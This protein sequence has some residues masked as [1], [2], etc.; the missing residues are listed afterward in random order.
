MTDDPIGEEIQEIVDQLEASLNAPSPAA[1]HA[2]LGQRQAARK[3]MLGAVGA[4]V[5]VLAIG[6]GALALTRDDPTSTVTADDVTEDVGDAATS[7]SSNGRTAV[8]QDSAPREVDR[9][10][11]DLPGADFRS[12]LASQAWNVG[13]VTGDSQGLESQFGRI[14][15]KG[16]PRTNIGTL[17]YANGCEGSA[18]EIDWINDSLAMVRS[19]LAVLPT[20]PTIGCVDVTRQSILVANSWITVNIASNT[21]LTFGTTCHPLGVC[22]PE[23]MW[24]VDLIGKDAFQ[25]LGEP[26]SGQATVV[27]QECANGSW[28]TFDGGKWIPWD[29]PASWA[30]Q[31]SVD[32]TVTVNGTSLVATDEV[33][34]S[35]SFRLDEGQVRVLICNGFTLEQRAPTD[36]HIFPP[37][38]P[39]P[40]TTTNAPPTGPPSF[41]PSADIAMSGQWEVVGLWDGEVPIDLEGFNGSIG[42]FGRSL[43]GSDGCNSH[44][45]GLFYATSDGQVQLQGGTST[46]VGC[47]DNEA[48]DLFRSATVGATNWGRTATGALVLTDGVVVVEFELT[49]AMPAATLQGVSAPLNTIWNSDIVGDYDNYDTNSSPV[50]FHFEGD[51]AVLTDQACGEFG[52]GVVF[53]DGTEGP[54]SFEALD[55][56]NP[57]ICE[58]TGDAATALEA[59]ARADY[60]AAAYG[61]VQLWDGPR[62][63]AIFADE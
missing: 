54:I 23:G 44:G 20:D 21:A 52:F 17:E 12:I 53:E 7:D 57:A 62:A 46:D 60:F 18:Y 25:L 43:N 34:N 19:E 10:P 26:Q 1:I 48:I 51:V 37:V 49:E 59:L 56:P 24:S 22:T 16:D 31:E 29:L 11:S 4:F 55:D 33:G 3:R 38:T 58:P 13:N 40:P 6:A 9:F 39:P 5:A 42:I 14:T 8:G 28:V 36:D 47:P 35:A 63:L 15:F 2:G 61:G 27:I 41:A 30:G 50:H 32:V 45:G